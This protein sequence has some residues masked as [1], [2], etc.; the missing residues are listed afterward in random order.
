MGTLHYG[1]TGD[2]IEMPDR[3]L[4]HLKVLISTKLRRNESF[5]LSWDRLIDG[6]VERSSIWLHCSIPLQFQMDAEASKQLDRAYLQQLA[7]QANSSTG[8]V[9]D[10]CDQVTEREISE[11][12]VST[13]AL[14]RV[15]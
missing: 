11:I 1:A 5:S 9:I 6:A 13:P 3:I 10:L 15:A 14:A 12:A 7:D 8:V 2:P 4:A